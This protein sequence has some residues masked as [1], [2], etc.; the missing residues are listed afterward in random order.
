MKSP[1]HEYDKRTEY[2]HTTCKS[3][4]IYC[5]AKDTRNEKIKAGKKKYMFSESVI[6]ES[7]FRTTHK[8]PGRF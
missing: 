8:K 5:K 2:C 7:C 1:C 3:H 6:V 4:G